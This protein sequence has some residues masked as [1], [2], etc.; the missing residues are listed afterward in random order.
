M[1]GVDFV[2]FRLGWDKYKPTDEHL[3]AIKNFKVPD[4]PS[5]SDIRSWYGFVNQLAPFLATAPIMNIFK[6]LLK[7]PCGK[8]E[9]FHRAQDTICHLAKDGLAYYDKTRPTVALTEWSR[10]GIG[11]II[12][13]QF[14][15]CSSAVAPFCCRAGWCLALCGSCHLTAAKTGYAA[16][17]GEALAVVKYLPG[18]RKAA[19][20]FLSRYPALRSP[21]TDT[22]A[23][24]DEDLTE[25]VA[26]AVIATVE[27]EDHI[28][29]ESA[30]RKSAA[31]DPVYQL[32]LAKVLAA[33]WHQHKSQ[34]VACLRPF[35]GMRDRLAVNQDL[36][37]YTFDQGC[38]R[39][40]MPEPSTHG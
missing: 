36:G 27:H 8:S 11:F 12:L 21:T 3:A 16:V 18:K 39:L 30:V 38:V 2:G 35:Y 23:N 24:L 37:T 5:I 19:A 1:E 6:K 9:K 4:K 28:L 25:A 26:A 32:L 34:E 40:V 10:K 29:D 31:D 20:D 33:D 13:Q 7:K 22:D 17:E 14:C 15:H